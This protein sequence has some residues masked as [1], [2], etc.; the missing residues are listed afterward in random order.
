MKK[1]VFLALIAGALLAAGFQKHIHYRSFQID[2]TSQKPLT[3]GQNTLILRIEK[4]NIKIKQMKVKFFMPEMPGMPYM[5]SW[6]S[7]HREN[8]SFKITTNL[9]M[10]GTWQMHIFITTLDGKKY[11][12][13][14]SVSF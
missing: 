5:E 9:P 1:I 13:K 7:V 12:I 4:P 6:A 3:T 2:L 10:A 11:R 14:S 8:K